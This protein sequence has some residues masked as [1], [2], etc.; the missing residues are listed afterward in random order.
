MGMEAIWRND[1]VV[2]YLRRGEFGF[3]INSSIGY[4]Y[5][6]GPGPDEP[7]D[8]Q[9]LLDGEYFIESMGVK[10][11]AKIHL[12]SVFDPENRRLQGIY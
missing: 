4:G 3:S 6:S 5:V 10:Y 8:D 1:R 11:P 9:Y 7:I 12:K 2:G